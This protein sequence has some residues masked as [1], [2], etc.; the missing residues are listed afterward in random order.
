MKYTTR[1]ILTVA[2]AA[3]TLCCLIAK[4]LILFMLLVYPLLTGWV[5]G[6]CLNIPQEQL[7][8]QIRRVTAKITRLFSEIFHKEDSNFQNDIQ[9]F[10]EKAGWTRSELAELVDCSV[11]T[12]V[13]IEN[14]KYIP[15]LTLAS[16][17]SEVFEVVINDLFVYKSTDEEQR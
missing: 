1:W 2:I 7:P 8:K 10:R 11:Q 4:D 12:I 3:L 17:L 6:E 9:Y 15:S 5:V 14:G 16:K 13:S